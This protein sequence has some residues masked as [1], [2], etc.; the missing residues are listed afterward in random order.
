MCYSEMF[1]RI[2]RIML[3]R[4]PVDRDDQIMDYTFNRPGGGSFKGE[5][6]LDEIID[7]F[8]ADRQRAYL[9]SVGTD[10]RQLAERSS[11]VTVIALHRKGCGGRYYWRQLYRRRFKALQPRIQLEAELSL[12]TV[13]ELTKALEPRLNVLTVVPEFELEVHVDIGKNGATGRLINQ[14]AGMISG[15]G[16]QVR[17]KPEAY[18]AA[19]LADSHV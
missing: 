10:S 6:I 5:E 3:E 4:N 14:I 13:M 18:C 9:L 11:F 12:Q 8:Q 2:L 17:T 15:C 7:Y 16:Y 19:V 1:L